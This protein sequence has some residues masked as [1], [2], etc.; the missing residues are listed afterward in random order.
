VAIQKGVGGDLSAVLDSFSPLTLAYFVLFFLLGYFLFVALFAAIGAVCNTEQEAQNLQGGV[1][2][3]LVIPMLST[4]FFINHPDS[5]LA[6]VAS[7]IPIVTPMLM[8]MRIS[9][10]TPP[11]WQIAL[12]VVLT[13]LTIW[14]LMRGV[15]KIFRIGILMYGKKPTVPEILR[16]ARTSS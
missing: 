8:Y 2:M 12:S 13:S 11:F 3:C 15:A 1:S 6:I 14:F 4:F 7:L 5:T 9:V 10:L 16:W